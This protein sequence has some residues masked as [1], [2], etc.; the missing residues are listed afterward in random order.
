LL[1]S[2]VGGRSPIEAT[3]PVA[4]TI[5]WSDAGTI[6]VPAGRFPA[7]LAEVCV[8]W[9][10]IDRFWFDAAFPHV[11]LK[12][13]TVAGR[14]LELRKTQR[15]DYWKHHAVGEEKLVE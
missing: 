1:P 4:A 15:L 9:G 6:S 7:R 13:E 14:S 5:Y 12:M 10:G 3:K 8:T 11:L 2:Q